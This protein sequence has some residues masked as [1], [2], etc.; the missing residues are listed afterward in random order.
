M[1]HRPLGPSGACAEFAGREPRE[2]NRIAIPIVEAICA[3]HMATG[4]DQPLGIRLYRICS[5]TPALDWFLLTKRPQNIRN[6]LPTDW[7]EGW[8]NVWLGTTTKNQEE[9]NRRIPYLVAVP[10]AVRFLSVEPMLEPV[11]VTPW[12]VLSSGDRRAPISW[13]IVGGESGGGARPT[14]P[15]WI[16]GLRDQEH[17]AGAQLFVK[18]IGSNHTFLARCHQQGRRPGTMA[19]RFAGAG[20]PAMKSFCSSLGLG[21]HR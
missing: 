7:G 9:A 20:L 4:V 11:D 18:Q 19:G 10:A 13:I 16:R 12:L 3:A 8:P 2:Y 17:G 1:H 15:D 14:H 21:R 6:M 5:S